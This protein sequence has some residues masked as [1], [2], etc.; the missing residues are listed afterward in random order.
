MNIK[1]SLFEQESERLVKARARSYSIEILSA[2]DP[3]VSVTEIIEEN[4]ETITV[5]LSKRRRWIFSVF[6]YGCQQHPVSITKE[7]SESNCHYPIKKVHN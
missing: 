1:F 4:N 2:D 7:L 6:A 3:Q 5:V